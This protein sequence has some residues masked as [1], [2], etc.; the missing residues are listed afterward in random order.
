MTEVHLCEYNFVCIHI[1]SI[2]GISLGTV[3][4][5]DDGFSRLTTW[6]RCS[7]KGSLLF[8]IILTIDVQR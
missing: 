3:A 8:I 4:N 2:S 6:Q 7:P 5:L 1:S